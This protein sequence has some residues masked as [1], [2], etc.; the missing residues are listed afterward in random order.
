[1]QKLRPI[2]FNTEMVRAILDGR[3]NVTRRVMKPQPVL[4]GCFWEWGGARWSDTIPSFTPLPCHSLYNRAPFHVGDTLYVR[5]TWTEIPDLFGEFPQYIYRANYSVDE[6]KYEETPEE[7][8][9]DFPSCV[10]WKPSIHMPKEAARIFLRVKNVRLERMQAISADECAM[11]G[12]WP[13]YAGPIGGREEYYKTAFEK[14]WD[15]TIKQEDIQTYGWEANPWVW[16]IEFERIIKE[17]RR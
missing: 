17:T 11:E 10:R 15:S 16:V 7:L 1:M 6:L 12:I 2:L 3:K 5:E 9:T 8:Y 13:L 14:L 4:N